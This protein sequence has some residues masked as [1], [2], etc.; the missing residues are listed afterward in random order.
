MTI[1]CWTPYYVQGIV[2]SAL[3]KVFVNT[4]YNPLKVL[5]LLCVMNKKVRLGEVI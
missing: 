5:L 1:I 2:P 4:L 3:C